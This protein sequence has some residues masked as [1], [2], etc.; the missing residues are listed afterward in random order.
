[1]RPKIFIIIIIII[2]ISH[3]NTLWFLS[4][5]ANALRKEN[6]LKSYC[7]EIIQYSSNTDLIFILLI[8]QQLQTEWKIHCQITMEDIVWRLIWRWW[9]MSV[10]EALVRDVLNCYTRFSP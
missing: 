3:F 4:F 10:M 7:I 2:F 5:S 6:F 1:M 8:P 9:F